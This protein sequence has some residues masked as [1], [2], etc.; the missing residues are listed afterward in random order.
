MRNFRPLPDV[1]KLFV[2]GICLALCADFLLPGCAKNEESGSPQNEPAAPDTVVDPG[3]ASALFTN[4]SQITNPY[5]PLTPGKTR[6]FLS[7]TEDGVEVTVLEVPSTTRVVAGVVCRVMRDRVYLDDVLIEDTEDYRDH[8]ATVDQEGKRIWLYPKQPK[9]RFYN[10]RTW[11]SFIFLVIF[12]TMPFI[13]VD[14]EQFLLFNVLERKFVLFGLL[15]TPQDF[16]LFVLAMLTF[17]VFIILFT[18]VF[19]RLFCGWVCPQTI[20]WK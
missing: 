12:L 19:G 16:H 18:V 9:G 8:I 10:A 4:P 15:F 7:V 3:F 14:G 6:V 5:F 11:V 20:S 13:K 17:I 1:R 2:G